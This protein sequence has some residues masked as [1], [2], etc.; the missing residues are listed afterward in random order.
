M[1]K[2]KMEFSVNIIFSP[3]K[4]YIF[5][6]NQKDNI[7]FEKNFNLQ[8]DPP[9]GNKKNSANLPDIENEW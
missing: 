6:I 1:S 3:P 7:F 4:G 8:G 2:H 9:Q 5:D